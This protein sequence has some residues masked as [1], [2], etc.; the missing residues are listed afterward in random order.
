MPPKSKEILI[1][2]EKYEQTLIHFKRDP[3]AEGFCLECDESVIVIRLDDAA[4]SLKVG[5][6]D[7][8]ELIDSGAVH[9]I[10]EADGIISLCGWSLAVRIAGS[11]RA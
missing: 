4:R 2:S 10:E 11:E 5:T 3:S 8:L 6:R 7:L 9:G 1:T